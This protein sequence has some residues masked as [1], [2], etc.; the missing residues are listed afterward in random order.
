M[1]L[2]TNGVPSKDA[3]LIAPNKV[4]TLNP[5]AAEFVPSA[6]RSTSGN[7]ENYDPTRLSIP[8]PS[9]QAFQDPSESSVLNKSDDEAHK[10]WSDQLPDDITPDFKVVGQDDLQTDKYM[11]LTSLSLNDGLEASRFPVS[12]NSQLMV[13]GQDVYIRG[14]RDSLNLTGTGYSATASAGYGL[15][16]PLMA[17][18][19]NKRVNQFINSD[20]FMKGGE[21]RRY[22]VEPMDF[23]SKAYISNRNIISDYLVSQ[24]PAFAPETIADAY[25]A[26]GCD[27][28]STI[29]IL[30]QQ[31][32]QHGIPSHN[33]S[34][35]PLV[36]PRL[37][38][39]DFPASSMVE[40]NDREESDRWRY[41]RNDSSDS[42]DFP[43]GKPFH[44]AIS[45]H[46]DAA[47]THRWLGTGE[48]VAREYLDSAEEI[49]DY[50]RP[51]NL[52]LEQ[53]RQSYSVDNKA[54]VKG[55]L[56]AL[57]RR[58]SFGKVRENINQ[59]RNTVVSENRGYTRGQNPLIDLHDLHWGE[60]IHLVKHELS[61]L[62]N[63]AKSARQQ[64]QVMICVG[65]AQHTRCCRTPSLMPL[66]E[67]YLQ[68]E[69]LQYSRPQPDLIRV[70]I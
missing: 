45:Q 18:L 31:Q 67:Y 65:T 25:Y 38:M 64:L 63:M 69:G 12:S 42:S 66:I 37:S 51:G 4:V 2:S 41:E 57:Q 58:A 35:K 23:N 54:F 27:L 61:I 28:K 62:R 50:T 46:F 49:H 11:S 32:L 52:F 3:K 30:N 43:I 17:S 34:L 8:G 33:F 29:E 24:F 16:P 55:N 21:G 14:G 48:A 68:G 22:Q 19:S 40:V 53:P 6:L 47:Q 9:G 70:L 59:P 1:N 20:Q 15:S 60:A 36:S 26:N 44:T 7:V 13:P 56:H 10:Y 39:L 5:N